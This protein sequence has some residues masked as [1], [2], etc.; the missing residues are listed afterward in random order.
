MSNCVCRCKLRFEAMFRPEI[1]VLADY[2]A[3]T[4]PEWKACRSIKGM[5]GRKRLKIM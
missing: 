4:V 5:A 3:A 2:I 1:L